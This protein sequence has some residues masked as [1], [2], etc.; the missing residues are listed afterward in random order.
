MKDPKWL[1]RVIEVFD[2]KTERLVAEHRIENIDVHMLQAV[3]GC[4]ADDPMVDGYDIYRPQAI[5]LESH[6]NCQFDLDR[7]DYQ[8]ATYTADF[9]QAR[10]EGGYAGL[11]PPPRDLPAFPDAK[12]FKSKSDAS[13]E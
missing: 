13:D 11:Y 10:A 4:A 7:F 2:K 8:L 1:E 5:L 6:S 3:F 9:E 12:R